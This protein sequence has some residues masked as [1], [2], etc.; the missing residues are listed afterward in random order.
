MSKTF[1]SFFSTVNHMW[2]VKKYLKISSIIFFHFSANEED[3]FFIL[4]DISRKVPILYISCRNHSC[5]EKEP[6]SLLCAHVISD[7][8]YKICLVA[9]QKVQNR[10]D[11]NKRAISYTRTV[12][13]Y[14]CL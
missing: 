1:F 14:L 10:L 2:Q 7:F 9:K 8:L 6:G 4:L 11:L 5:I 3:I 12:T 13:V